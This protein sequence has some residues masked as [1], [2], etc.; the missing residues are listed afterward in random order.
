VRDDPSVNHVLM[1]L[2]LDSQGRQR[3]L[4]SPGRRPLLK[5]LT[6]V[7]QTPHPHHRHAGPLGGDEFGV[8][9]ADCTLDT[10]TAS[11][12]TCARPYATSASSGRTA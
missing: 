12:R 2:D 6:S 8:L 4:R 10:A 5:Q 7:V 9:L 11:P 1:Y 3:H